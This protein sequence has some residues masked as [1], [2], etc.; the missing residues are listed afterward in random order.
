MHVEYQESIF[1][2]STHSRDMTPLTIKP[3][4]VDHAHMRVLPCGPARVY[5]ILYDRTAM[6]GWQTH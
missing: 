3:W 1:A 5:I 4:P 6:T 2:C